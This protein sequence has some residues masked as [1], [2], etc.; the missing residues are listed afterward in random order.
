MPYS[1][2]ENLSSGI[3]DFS[4]AAFSSVEPFTWPLFFIGIIGFIYAGMH[5]LVV[6]VV[7][8]LITLGTFVGTTTIF[9]DIPELTQFLYIISIIGIALLLAMVV[10]KTRQ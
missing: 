7:G 6:A 10:I 1:I 5:S 8:I 4:M 9:T 2:F 3:R